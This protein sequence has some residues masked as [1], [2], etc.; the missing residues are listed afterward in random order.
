M[1]EYLSPADMADARNDV[2]AS[3]AGMG[4]FSVGR[5]WRVHNPHDPFQWRVTRKLGH[6]VRI[7]RYRTEREAITGHATA[8]A[9]TVLLAERAGR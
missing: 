5:P 4:P 3:A 2:R 1:A 8:V 7:D 9:D 6:I